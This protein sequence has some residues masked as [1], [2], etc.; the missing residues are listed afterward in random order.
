M[1]AY[2]RFLQGTKH[3]LNLPGDAD[4]GEKLFFGNAGCS[5]C[6]MT[7]GKGGFIASDLSG[8][9]RTHSVDQIRNAITTPG[10]TTGRPG[11]LR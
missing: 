2:L 9:A 7:A 8:Y 10:G 5:G 4:R 1:V 11:W 6:H 3:A